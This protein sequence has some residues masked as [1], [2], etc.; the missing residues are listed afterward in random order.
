MKFRPESFPTMITPYHSDGSVDYETAA[1]YVEWYFNGGCDGIFAICQSSEIFFL[2]LEERVKL[3]KTVLEKRDELAE[4]YGRRMTVVASGHVS[5][6]LDDQ[7]NELKAVASLRPDAVILITNRLADEN[8]SDEVW[9]ENA[10]KLLAGLPSDIKF[11]MYECP[12]PYKRL[13]TEKTLKWAAEKGN[14]TYMKDTCC[15][16][17]EIRR[18]LEI[19]KGSNLKLLNANCQ[20]LLESLRDGGQGYCGIMANYHPELYA[21]ICHNFDSKPEKAELIG[22][23][24]C[25][26]GFTEAGLPYPLSAKY[27]MNL[28][29]IPTEV[30]ARNRKGEVFTDYQKNCVGQMKDLATYFYSLLD[31]N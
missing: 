21:W 1:S 31:E 30:T 20:T 10:E 23:F 22:K 13:V 15:N 24:L 11:G 18:R 7:I 26:S 2:S 17:A 5:E 28:V 25:T 9:I 4:K 29:G 16:A 12:S 14:F 6:S 27:H 3:L 19:I 8:E